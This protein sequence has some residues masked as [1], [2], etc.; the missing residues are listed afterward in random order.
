MNTRYTYDDIYGMLK[1]RYVDEEPTK[2]IADSYGV[3]PGSIRAIM[4]GTRHP[5][6]FEQF[7]QDYPGT[8]LPGG[9][10]KLTQID[11]EE[12]AEI[13]VRMLEERYPQEEDA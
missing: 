5:G 10:M 6:I 4:A 2:S 8:V 3:H 7:K 11:K 13:V 1:R 12:I 9:R